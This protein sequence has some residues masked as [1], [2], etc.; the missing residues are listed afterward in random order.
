MDIAKLLLVVA[1]CIGTCCVWAWRSSK[2]EDEQVD[3]EQK[4][5]SDYERTEDAVR[6]A[7]IRSGL[8]GDHASLDVD[9]MITYM[10]RFVV[11]ERSESY[12]EGFWNGQHARIERVPMDMSPEELE[13]LKSTINKTQKED[14]QKSSN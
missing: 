12:K 2:N 4:E 11:K 3:Y 9:M 13:E 6:D 10:Y 8:Q 14:E 5:K 1:L 7:L